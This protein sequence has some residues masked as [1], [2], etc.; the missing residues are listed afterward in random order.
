MEPKIRMRGRR[1]IAGGKELQRLVVFWVFSMVLY[2]V[3]RLTK[4]FVRG[5]VKWSV[6]SRTSVCYNVMTFLKLGIV[7]W[8]FGSFLE[9]NYCV[10]LEWLRFRG[11][12][13][14]NE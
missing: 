8:P 11:S 10:V 7:F 6:R 9:N 5:I 12:W 4:F 13:L 14:G 1:P 2:F 3:R